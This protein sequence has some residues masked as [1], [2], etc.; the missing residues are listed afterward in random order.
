M[1]SNLSRSNKTKIGGH[2]AFNRPNITRCLKY[3]L[4]RIQYI[5]GHGANQD[6]SLG[7]F[8]NG[9]EFGNGVG[10]NVAQMDCRAVRF[11]G[12]YA[13]FVLGGGTA[14]NMH[15][16]KDLCVREV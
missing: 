9:F 2:D 3:L 15:V 1:K 11:E 16:L 14:E 8:K 7:G 5:P 6:F 4:L 10:C 12:C 13:G